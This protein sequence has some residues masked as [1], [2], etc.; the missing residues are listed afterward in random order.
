MEI[1]EIHVKIDNLYDSIIIEQKLLK[2]QN[3]I[4]T[5]IELLF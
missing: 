5:L 1:Y 3:L 4:V 2:S